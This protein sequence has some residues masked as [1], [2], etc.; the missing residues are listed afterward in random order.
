VRG[1]TA[2]NCEVGLKAGYPESKALVDLSVFY[3]D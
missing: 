3:V 2:I 1:E